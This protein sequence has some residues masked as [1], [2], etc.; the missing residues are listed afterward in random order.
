MMSALAFIVQPWQLLNGASK[1]LNVLGGYGVFLGPMTGIM[2]ADYFIVRKRLYKLTH[3]YNANASSIYWYWKG[4]N[5]RALAAWVM[6]VWIT[7]PGFA[8]RVGKPDEELKGWSHM[9]YFSWPLGTLIAMAVYVLINR[10][11]V[12]PGLGEQDQE[13]VF[14]TFGPAVFQEVEDEETS[15]STSS[16]TVEVKVG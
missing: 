14:G 10:I 3:L 16:V 4:C 6:G 15:R 9:Y 12:V 8:Q 1:F 7:L 2:F 5:W 11:W 13:D